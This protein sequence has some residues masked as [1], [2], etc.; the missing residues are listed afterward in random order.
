L[1]LNLLIMKPAKKIVLF[2]LFFIGSQFILSAYNQLTVS[3]VRFANY[4]RPGSIDSAFLVVRSKGLYTEQSMYLTISA[5]GQGFK[6]TDS[7]EISYRFDL[8]AGAI[9]TDTW[10][11]LDENT[12]SKG[13]LYDKWTASGI[14]ENI[15]KRRRDPSLLFKESATQYLLKIFPMSGTGSRKIKITY[16]IPSTIGRDKLSSQLVSNY[17]N[18]GFSKVDLL[19]VVYFEHAGYTSPAVF[20]S[21]GEPV[22]LY[23]KSDP[24]GAIYYNGISLF[25]DYSENMEFIVQVLKPSPVIFSTYERNGEQYYQLA[26]EPNSFL[27]SKPTHSLMI[28]LDLD[29]SNIVGKI[30]VFSSIITNLK[31]E[32]GDKDEF[33]VSFTKGFQYQLYSTQ[34]L[35]ATDDKI[36]EVFNNISNQISSISS[37]ALLMNETLHWM[38]N[39]GAGGNILFITS[40]AGFHNVSSA[41]LLIEALKSEGLERVP[42]HIADVSSVNVNCSN[43][44]SQYFCNNQYFLT[45]LARISRGSSN[46]FLGGQQSLIG[47]IGIAVTNSVPVLTNPQIYPKP[48]NGYTY[49]RYH[50]VTYDKIGL[51]EFIF[52]VGKYKGEL[53]FFIDITGES[54]G[55]VYNKFLQIDSSYL[56][57][58]DKTLEQIWADYQIKYYEAAGGKNPA[59]ISD[60]ISLSIDSRVMSLYTAFLCLEDS[61]YFCPNCVDETKTSTGTKVDKKDVQFIVSPNPFTE[62]IQI[63]LN[64]VSDH[65]NEL[66]LIQVYD[67]QGKLMYQTRGGTW[68]GEVLSFDLNLSELKSG[69]YILVVKLKDKVFKKKIIKL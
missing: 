22:S 23:R 24:S 48:L 43:Y 31:K 5:R 21:K 39:S 63:V 30:P 58:T 28:C 4:V 11:W 12:I 46:V 37:S 2:I 35:N 47:T 3:D 60:A 66:A 53:P 32:L 50:P 49:S 6:V 27:E 26:I 55:K 38:I 9:V 57:A 56:V 13:K 61:S 44:G 64:A 1:H 41:N 34:W 67:L 52:Q 29:M 51:N 45:N 8:P 25:K 10:L 36:E 42:F 19:K 65:V 59:R 40:G 62:Q 20:N 18:V 17:L 16:L 14:Y 15:V 7:L 54:E 69:M 68:A 33:N